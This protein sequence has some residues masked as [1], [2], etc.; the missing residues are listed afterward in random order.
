[1]TLLQKTSN[2]RTPSNIGSMLDQFF[3]NDMF[4][5]SNDNFSMG[6]TT[7]PAVN[8]RELDEEFVVEVAAPGMKRDDFKVEVDGDMLR[9]S[10]ERQEERKDEDKDSRYT[11]REFSYQSFMRSF[12]L[13]NT[14]E[15][16]KIKAKYTDGV[17]HLS[18]PKKEEARPKPSRVIKIS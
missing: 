3:N 8:I 4:N 7:L 9:I 12:N 15:A 1:M 13:P 14:V 18:I 16:D 11:R 6:N 2:G 5:W 17:L 10:S